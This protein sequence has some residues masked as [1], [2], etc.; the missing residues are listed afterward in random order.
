VS[1]AVPNPSGSIRN[2]HV[3]VWLS[4]WGWWWQA[5]FLDPVEVERIVL[6]PFLA[7]FQVTTFRTPKLPEGL[8]EEIA[9]VHRVLA[10]EEAAA[11]EAA[12]GGGGGGGGG[13]NPRTPT[14]LHDPTAQDLS[15]SPIS[16]LIISRPL[17]PQAA[18]AVWGVVGSLRERRWT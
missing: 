17:S 11:A 10:T 1:F 2:F 8:L 9:A 16:R 15:V 6:R 5:W 13:E 14:V 3:A 12:A 4:A 7:R 18:E